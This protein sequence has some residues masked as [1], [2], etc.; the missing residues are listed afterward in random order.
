MPNQTAD[1]IT[2]ELVKILEGLGCQ[3]SSIPTRVTILRVPFSNRRR[4]CLAY[5]NLVRRHIT[6]KGMEWLRGS[7]GHCSRCCG[8]MLKMR[9]T[10]NAICRSYFSP[11]K[12]Q[13]ILH[14]GC[15]PSS[16]C[17]VALPSYMHCLPSMPLT[18]APT[19]TSCAQLL[20]VH[21]ILKM[22]TLHKQLSSEGSIR[23]S[24]TRLFSSSW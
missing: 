15:P 23:S 11:I 24:H 12:Q 4:T 3:T 10:G 19:S 21:K 22:H 7:T 20:L 8:C 16:S 9:L 17:L 5:R 13:S 18:P 2:T 6:C 14:Q 1:T